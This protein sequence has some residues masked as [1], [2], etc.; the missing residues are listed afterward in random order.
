MS[1]LCG[2]I[3]GQLVVVKQGPA[4][5]SPKGYA[6]EK[7]LCMCACGKIT[8]VRKDRLE[9]GTTTSCGCKKH[10]DNISCM[11]WC[12]F[13]PYGVECTELKCESCGWNPFNN[14]L[15]EKRIMKLM[16]KDGT[17]ECEVYT[18]DENS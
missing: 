14:D 10:G 9:K 17:D 18:A 5:I 7:Y 3:F 11:K 12:A 8:V 16:R 4:Y 13:S 6:T 2:K 15:R 1:D